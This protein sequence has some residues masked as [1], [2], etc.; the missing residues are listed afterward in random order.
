M[1]LPII[2]YT[3]FIQLAAGRDIE[4]RGLDAEMLA[5]FVSGLGAIWI[6]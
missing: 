1:L 3:L 5:I 2:T 6:C 4:T